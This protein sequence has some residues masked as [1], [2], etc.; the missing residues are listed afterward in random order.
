MENIPLFLSLGAVIL[1]AFWIIKKAVKLAIVGAIAAVGL[2][3]W[4]TQIN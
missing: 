4:F 2:W 3:F 1:V